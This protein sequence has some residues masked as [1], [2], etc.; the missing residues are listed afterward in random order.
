MSSTMKQGQRLPEAVSPERIAA[1]QDGL[2]ARETL[3]D[4][5][6]VFRAL[7]SPV[8]LCIMHALSHHELSVGDLARALSL[9]LSVTSHQL[10]WLRHMKLVE[11]RD[12]GRLTF[13]RATDAFVAHLVHDCLAHVGDARPGAARPHHHS[14][15]L[16][17]DAPPQTA[18]RRRRKT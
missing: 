5:V 6:E 8:R 2:P 14:H 3:A 12:K 7:A 13:Y 9:S 16:R 15:H 1:T 11:A 18:T 17:T 10:A 4:A